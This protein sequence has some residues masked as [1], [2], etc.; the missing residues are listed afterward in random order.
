MQ[1]GSAGKESTCNAGDLGLIPGLGRS[2]GEGHG[3]PLQYSGLKNSMDCIVHGV[4]KSRT[5]L[6]DF[7]FH[8]LSHNIKLLQYY[9]L[10]S[11]FYTYFITDI[12]ASYPLNLLFTSPLP[13]HLAVTSSLYLWVFFCYVM[14]ICLFWFFSSVTQLCPTLCDPINRSMPGLPVHQ[15][16]PEFTQ[17]HVHRISDAIQPC[18]PLSSPSPPAPSPSQHQGLFQWVNSSH[19]VAKVLEFHL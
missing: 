10:Y 18:H 4:A 16:L 17:T 6:S 7:H 9:W 15:Q 19:E 8:C 1:C 12:Y 14:F 13:L 3:N 2:P 5:R 11:L